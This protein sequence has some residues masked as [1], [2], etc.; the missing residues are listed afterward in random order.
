VI[1]PKCSQSVGP[2]TA[3]SKC[4]LCGFSLRAFQQ[5]MT[6]LYLLSTAFFVST[7]IYGGL[8]YLL[9]TQRLLQPA[10]MPGFLPYLLLVLA[11]LVFGVAI[12]VGQR[13]ATATTMAAVQRLIII[14][15]G[16]IESIAIYG[17]LIYML[18]NSLQWFVTFLAL[19]LLGFMQTASQMPSV[20][21]QLSRLAV[22]EEEQREGAERFSR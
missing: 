11:V 22:I 9:D 12:K 17:L 18:S 4:P 10:G 21:E 1:C 3:E 5:Q 7:V 15:L 14:K 6:R 2:A 8:V 13:V 19:A 20:A 16:L